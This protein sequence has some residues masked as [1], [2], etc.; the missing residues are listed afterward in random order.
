M[1]SIVAETSLDYS[2]YII[3]EIQRFQYDVRTREQYKDDRE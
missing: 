3:V 1:A 2:V